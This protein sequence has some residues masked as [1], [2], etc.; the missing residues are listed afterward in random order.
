MPIFETTLTQAFLA[1]L[2]CMLGEG[3]A[4][5][6]G[7]GFIIQPA[8]L[9]LGV[10]PQLVIANDA[11]AAGGASLSSYHVFTRHSKI[12]NRFILWWAPGLIL[13]PFIGIKLLTLVSPEYLEKIIITCSLIGALLVVFKRKENQ[14]EHSV[15]H[16]K[17]LS[18]I[19]GLVFGIWCGFSGLG[20]GTISLTILMLV[21][22]Q[23]IKQA[24][25]NQTPIHV[26]SDIVVFLGFLIQGWLV[27]KLLVPMLLGCLAGGYLGAHMVLR[28]S[29]RILKLVFLGSVMIITAITILKH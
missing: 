25:I 28:L 18:L 29:E 8:L 6:G 26:I 1:F 21:F 22:G 5:Y 20:S 17:I 16:A 19:C 9:A 2:V 3:I 12:D 23:T 7:A 14:T 13:G 15:H 24:S 4:I 27:W 10:P 11:A